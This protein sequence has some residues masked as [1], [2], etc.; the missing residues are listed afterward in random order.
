[1][2]NVWIEKTGSADVMK[3]KSGPDIDRISDDEVLIDVHFS[4]LNFADIMMRL[5]LYPDAPKKPFIPGYEIS[6]TVKKI[7]AAVRG[8]QVGESVVAGTLFGG[9]S[10]EIKVSQDLVFKLPPQMS[11]AKGAALPVNWITAH[12]ALAD[13]GR[14]RKGDRVLIDAAT[15][16]V[17][18]IAL[19]MLRERQADVVGLTS[20]ES[21]LE[22]IRRLGAKAMT[23]QEFNADKSLPPF[24]LIPK[25]ARWTFRPY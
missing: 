4:G 3:I 2:K 19:Q 16:G 15:G 18:T 25:F 1:M 11:L 23:H 8:V 10:S 9:Y 22:Y 17:G 12:A 6:G 14:V 21:K 20:S 7:G 24:D 5:G 13:M